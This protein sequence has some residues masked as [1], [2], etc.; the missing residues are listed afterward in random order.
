MQELL[1][2]GPH[3]NDA[4]EHSLSLLLYLVLRASALPAE[5]LKLVQIPVYTIKWQVTRIANNNEKDFSAFIFVALFAFQTISVYSYLV[6][7]T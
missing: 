4:N 6:P 2:K 7:T 5:E 3:F 1:Y